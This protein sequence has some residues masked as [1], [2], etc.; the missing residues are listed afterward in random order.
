VLSS[1]IT[2]INRTIQQGFQGIGTSSV[3]ELNES[4]DDPWL[5]YHLAETEFADMNL[6]EAGKY[7]IRIYDS[8][9]LSTEQREMSMIR[10]AQ[11]S[12]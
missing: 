5:I 6:N 3:Q 11:I 4:P 10:L 12:A 9:E 8:S 7:F 1:I 2:G